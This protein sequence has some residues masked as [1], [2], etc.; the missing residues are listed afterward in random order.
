MLNPAT[1]GLFELQVT[2]QVCLLCHVE[3]T[4]EHRGAA[5]TKHPRQRWAEGRP[6]GCGTADWASDSFV[7]FWSND[8]M[9]SVVTKR[10]KG[11]MKVPAVTPA[12]V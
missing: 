9:I 12:C 2:V 11:G 7:W 8:Q 10:P 5:E 4:S 3:E 1:R 6:H